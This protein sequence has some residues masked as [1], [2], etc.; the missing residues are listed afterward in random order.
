MAPSNYE[1]HPFPMGS[2]PAPG[3]FQ[4]SLSTGVVNGT[5]GV[6]P[7]YN[8]YLTQNNRQLV[9]PP[10]TPMFSRNFGLAQNPYGAHQPQLGPMGTMEPRQMYAGAT[11]GSN[12]FNSGIQATT[13]LQTPGW[14]PPGPYAPFRSAETFRASNPY[15][16]VRQ[17]FPAPAMASGQQH[18]AA[19]LSSTGSN[20]HTA[21]VGHPPTA[22]RPPQRAPLTASIPEAKQPSDQQ[23][24]ISPIAANEANNLLVNVPVRIENDIVA[25]GK[26]VRDIRQ[27]YAI[28][29]T[30]ELYA[31]TSLFR[32]NNIHSDNKRNGVKSPLEL[33]DQRVM[34]AHRLGQCKKNLAAIKDFALGIERPETQT[35]S[36]QTSSG[37][38][39][40]ER[41]TMPHKPKGGKQDAQMIG[42]VDVA[43]LDMSSSSNP[44]RVRKQASL[45]WIGHK[46]PFERTKRGI[47]KRPEFTAD[48]L[49]RFFAYHLQDDVPLTL[50]IQKAPE[51]IS[52]MTLGELA[53]LR[54]RFQ[55]CTQNE[56]RGI[57]DPYE[58][59][60][61]LDES[62]NNHLGANPGKIVGYVHLRCLEQKFH[63][64][65]LFTRIN[66]DVQMIQNFTG[67][68]VGASPGLPSGPALNMAKTFL[69]ACKFGTLGT[70][71][72]DYPGAQSNEPFP[73][74][75]T[76]ADELTLAYRMHRS[77]RLDKGA[78]DTEKD[79][80]IHVGR[81]TAN[82]AKPKKKSTTKSAKSIPPPKRK[83]QSRE[84]EEGD[85]SASDQY[86]HDASDTA[87]SAHA[88]FPIP[89]LPG[90]AKATDVV[91]PKVTSEQDIR[92]F[93]PP[94]IVDLGSEDE[95]ALNPERIFEAFKEFPELAADVLT[96]SE[97]T[98][99][100]TS[101]AETT[102]SDEAHTQRSK[103]AAAPGINPTATT[104]TASASGTSKLGDTDPGESFKE[105]TS[106]YTNEY[107]EM[108][109]HVTW[110]TVPRLKSDEPAESFLGAAKQ[111]L[112]DYNAKRGL[113]TEI[114]GFTDAEGDDE[115]DWHQA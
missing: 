45:G 29:R 18:P 95:V 56:H 13:R 19:N 61:A 57:I 87:L 44:Q 53:V 51:N 101:P 69:M 5:A 67:T 17:P 3:R 34:L 10:S 89:I 75:F 107:G 64:P 6:G 48:E 14:A 15:E 60:V 28:H 98:T 47:L 37:F 36:E 63:L 90:K 49:R 11:Y 8:P 42:E 80:D 100:L 66:A 104:A 46:A 92:R 111:M 65:T 105:I 86:S 79:D 25:L 94:D 93:D 31:E 110:D 81:P 33:T 55:L 22:A 1:Q 115:E 35:N 103:T 71:F 2:Q 16:H 9:S 96:T 23:L 91:P 83:V 102:K 12:T 113:H 73:M 30:L 84:I 54:C 108:R 59:R 26:Y 70:D 106:H 85:H 50:W 43:E 39:I 20:V 76:G 58:I 27:Q 72:P 74:G 41:I 62:P 38:I 24:T 112:L 77:L 88:G 78:T 114:E 7:G 32:C 97:S 109:Y 68:V 52:N 21:R 82:K 40:D 4:S 99:S